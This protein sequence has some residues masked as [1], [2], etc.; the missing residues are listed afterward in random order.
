VL[1]VEENKKKFA[2]FVPLFS[3]FYRAVFWRYF[4]NSIQPQRIFYFFCSQKIR[5]EICH[6][7][8]IFYS[9]FWFFKNPYA[10]R[11]FF[12]EFLKAKMVIII[13]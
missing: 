5:H 11:N 9:N 1:V 12:C 3:K 4:C 13:F 6:F 2:T 8:A 7:C 10:L